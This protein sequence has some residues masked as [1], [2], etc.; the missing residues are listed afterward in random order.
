MNEEY[1][2][3][4]LNKNY[5]L[6]GN[7]YQ[8]DNSPES[9]FNIVD[10][11]SGQVYQYVKI[12]KLIKTIFSDVANFAEWHNML[13]TRGREIRDTYLE[14]LIYTKTCDEII[15]EA[16]I[17][18]KEQ[19]IFGDGWVGNL[20]TND[21]LKKVIEPE[22]KDFVTPLFNKN[23]SSTIIK[24][25]MNHFK[26]SNSGLHEKY[27]HKV[28]LDLYKP[29]L[30]DKISTHLNKMDI[31]S[32]S[33]I[34]TKKLY[35][36]F[37]NEDTTLINKIDKKF[38]EFYESK[39]EKFVDDYIETLD[40]NK[41]TTCNQIKTSYSRYNIELVEYSQLVI[42][43]INK[44]YNEN[45]LDP[46]I[47]DFLSQ[48]IIRLGERDWNVYWIGHGLLNDVKMMGHFREENFQESHIQI[49][50]DNWYEN[51]VLIACEKE[52]KFN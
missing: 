34:L 1:I 19:N 38:K 29:Y 16:K 46:K 10:V 12:E 23:Q 31:D 14:N 3:K 39:V 49:R 17:Y 22:I 33:I 28:V 41:V 42:D 18:F 2:I 13:A 37:K 52:L 8:S 24:K 4:Y 30:D 32:G 48:L 43:K 9:M 51:A 7:Q 27:I 20:I 5:A 50:Y 15:E 35:N 21:Y 26:A 45:I 47:D 40:K 11:H 36:S 25:A 6:Y 44:W